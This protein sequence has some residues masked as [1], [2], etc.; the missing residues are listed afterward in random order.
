V[1][2]DTGQRMRAIDDV[3]A[4]VGGKCNRRVILAGGDYGEP[5]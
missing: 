4:L 1:E 3:G 2:E 5:G